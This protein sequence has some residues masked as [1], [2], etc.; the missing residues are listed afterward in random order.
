MPRW[1]SSIHEIRHFAKIG[2]A[3]AD[4]LLDDVTIRLYGGAQI[5]GYIIDCKMDTQTTDVPP[6]RPTAWSG[7]VRLN[8]DQGILELDYLTI[9]EITKS[10]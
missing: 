6:I 8:T 1:T 3:I 7:T 10:N 5:T 4:C 2:H 9:E